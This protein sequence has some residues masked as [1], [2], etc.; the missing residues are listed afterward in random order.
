MKDGLV[1]SGDEDGEGRCKDD[2]F[3]SKVS[4][5]AGPTIDCRVLDSMDGSN[6][7][8]ASHGDVEISTLVSHSIDGSDGGAASRSDVDGQGNCSAEIFGWIGDDDEFLSTFSMLIE[9]ILL[10]NDCCL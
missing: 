8:A 5:W 9:S 10:T 7:S 2:D 4:E 3:A 6:G 1:S